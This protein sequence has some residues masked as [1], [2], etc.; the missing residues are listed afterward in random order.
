MELVLDFQLISGR[1]SLWDSDSFI[2]IYIKLNQIFKVFSLN[3][4]EIIMFIDL[5]ILSIF[6][7]LN[8]N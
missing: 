3:C 5:N 4:L 2:D 6:S 1:V 7:F 8:R